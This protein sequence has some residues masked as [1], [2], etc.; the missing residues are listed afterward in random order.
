[1]IGPFH[2]LYR[3]QSSTRHSVAVSV[4]QREAPLAIRTSCFFEPSEA[5]I[6][7]YAGATSLPLRTEAKRSQRNVRRSVQIPFAWDSSATASRELDPQPLHGNFRF[8]SVFPPANLAER[9]SRTL[10]TAF[11]LVVTLFSGSGPATVTV[12]CVRGFGFFRKAL[13]SPGEMCQLDS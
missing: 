7:L 8:L 6:G 5:R 11:C 4:T 13:V 9:G 10:A 1:M 12:E 2:P 3:L